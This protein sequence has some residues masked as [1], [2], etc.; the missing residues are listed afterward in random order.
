MKMMAKNFRLVL[1]TMTTDWV[2]YRSLTKRGKRIMVYYSRK[3][4]QF[5]KFSTVFLALSVIGEVRQSN[6]IYYKI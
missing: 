4:R 5:N 3:G 6:N 2:D 1:H